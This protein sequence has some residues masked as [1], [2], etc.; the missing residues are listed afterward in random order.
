MLAPSAFLA[1]AAGTSSLQT[2]ILHK[3]RT[4]EEDMTG[5]ISCWQRLASSGDDV[6]LPVGTQKQL[7]SIVVTRAYRDLLDKQ[8]TQYHRARLL[9]A[10][11]THS[12]DWLYA[13]PISAC[14]LRLDDEAV[15][16]AIGMRLGSELCQPHRCPCGVL[17]DTLGSHALS[18]R[19]NSGRTQRHHYLNDLVWRALSRAGIP[20]VKEPHGLVRSDGKRPDG[21]TLVPWQAGRCATWDVTVTHTVADSFVGISAACA[22]AAAEAAANRKE[23]KYTD[24]SQSHLFFPVAFETMGPINQTGSDFLS[25]LGRRLAT[26]TDDPRESFFLFQRL[27]IAIQRY[28]TIC[29]TESFCSLRDDY[30]EHSRHT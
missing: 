13:V 21:L 17:V 9:A 22:G 28:N 30:T 14:G 11:A 5:P 18:C 1:S 26:V 29:F 27:S 16:V 6:Q 15:R 24:I 12:G 20:S 19:Q 8:T 10:A 4:A 3:C 23:A 25:L 2:Q 7:D